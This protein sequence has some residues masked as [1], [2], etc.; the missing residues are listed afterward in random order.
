MDITDEDFNENV[1]FLKDYNNWYNIPLLNYSSLHKSK[2]SS[3]VRFRGMIQD[4]LNPEIYLEK[5]EVLNS[6]KT[7]ESSHRIQSGKYRDNLVLK[8]NEFVNYD[9]TLNV[10]GERRL[11][12]IT[13]IP[14]FNKWASDVENNEI[15]KTSAVNNSINSNGQNDTNKRIRIDTATNSSVIFNS[16]ACSSSQ[17]I[18]IEYS[19]AACMVIV[20]SNF[21]DFA[22]NSVIETVG[23]LSINSS[24]DNSMDDYDSNEFKNQNDFVPRL[25]AI[26]FRKLEH[27]NPL[28]DISITRNGMYA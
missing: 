6:D 2:N 3:I 4:M 23:F 11:I 14:R 28:L 24:S 25:H 15:T 19:N 20:Y 26:A 8:E 12:Y 21:D 5:Y 18:S 22:L 16:V 13:S 10:Y 17:N 9:S 7:I 27:L 1:E